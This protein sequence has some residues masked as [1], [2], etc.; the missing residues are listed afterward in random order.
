[1][2]KYAWRERDIDTLNEDELRAALRECI[3]CLIRETKWTRTVVDMEER[4]TNVMERP[5]EPPLRGFR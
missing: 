4:F 1:M 5:V 2:T 3:E